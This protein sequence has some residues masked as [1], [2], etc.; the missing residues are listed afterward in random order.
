RKRE[1]LCIGAAKRV[2]KATKP[3][4][5]G[6]ALGRGKVDDLR[7]EVV[8][9]PDEGKDDGGDERRLQQGQNDAAIDG[10]AASAINHRRL[11]D[12]AWD[13]PDELDHQEDEEPVGRQE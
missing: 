1:Q 5:D 11:V 7:E 4:K 3:D 6:K 2:H 13:L 9:G 8:V 10:E 12:L